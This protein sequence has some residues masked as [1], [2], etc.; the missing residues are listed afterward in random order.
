MLE[1]LKEQVLKAN[2]ALVRH[3]LVIFTWGNVSGVDRESGIMAI[4]P[5]G[6]PYDRLTAEQL[7]LVSIASG[8]QVEGRLRPSSDT[9]THIALYKAFPQIGGV[10][11]T[12]SRF[13]TVFAQAGRPIPALGTTHADYFY[14]DIPVTRPLTRAEIEGAYE[15]ETGRVIE[16]TFLERSSDACPGALVNGHGPFAWGKDADEAVYHAAVLE[17]VATMAFYTMQ[18]APSAKLDDALIQKHYQRKHGNN[19]Y[20]GQAEK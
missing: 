1:L 15:L 9:P 11:H 8:E 18:L 6:V 12:H 20:Y 7:V 10:V 4:K 19:A 14:G 3:G 17:E 2:L 5:S 16:E 13:A